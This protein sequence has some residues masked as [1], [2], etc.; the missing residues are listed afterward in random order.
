MALEGCRFPC[1]VT[2]EVLKIPFRY[3]DLLYMLAWMSVISQGKLL[4]L[5]FYVSA[6]RIQVIT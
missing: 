4:P 6:Y 1:D 2:T 3:C 5:D